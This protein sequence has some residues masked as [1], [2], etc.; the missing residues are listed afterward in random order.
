RRRPSAHAGE[1][2]REKGKGKRKRSS[3]FLYPIADS[4]APGSLPPTLRGEPAAFLPS[5]PPHC[6]AAAAL[7]WYLNPA[8]GGLQ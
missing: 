5:L 4:H 6:D 8:F 2:V 1:L 3:R 7:C